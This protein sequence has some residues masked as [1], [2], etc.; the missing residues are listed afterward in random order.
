MRPGVQ[1]IKLC[2]WILVYNQK[3]INNL[4]KWSFLRKYQQIRLPNPKG[5]E[6]VER[7]DNRKAYEINTEQRD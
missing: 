1:G 5:L 4:K 3:I 2:L 6:R 7:L